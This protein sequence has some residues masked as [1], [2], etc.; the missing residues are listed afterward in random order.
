M[1]L[2]APLIFGV[3]L[4]SIGTVLLVFHK[5]IER[6]MAPPSLPRWWYFS[7]YQLGPALLIAGGVLV[8]VLRLLG[9][10]GIGPA[11]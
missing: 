7:V 8:I 4:I 9:L 2:A 6:W 5:A 10:A 11:A 3:A 1:T